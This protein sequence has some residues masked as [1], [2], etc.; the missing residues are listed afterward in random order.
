M[1]PGDYFFIRYSQLSLLGQYD[2]TMKAITEHYL[3]L[4]RHNGMPMCDFKVYRKERNLHDIFVQA[5]RR[6]ILLNKHKRHQMV[7]SKI[8]QM[9]PTNWGLN[10]T[11]ITSNDLQTVEN[12]L[13]ARLEEEDLLNTFNYARLQLQHAELEI[14]RTFDEFKIK[15]LEAYR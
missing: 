13:F 7:A 2:Q 6:L 12:K 11:K 1:S 4:V 5:L 9:N 3:E 10:K 8:E 15:C 14:N